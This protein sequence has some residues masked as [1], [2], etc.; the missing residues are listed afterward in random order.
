MKETSAM[1]FCHCLDWMSESIVAC[2]LELE[3]P[4]GA[5]HPSRYLIA[6]DALQSACARCLAAIQTTQL[7]FISR[8]AA[9]SP[10]L[11]SVL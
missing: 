7:S 1:G 9:G 5:Q 2:V 6:T 4:L 10:E 3:L 8:F 11:W